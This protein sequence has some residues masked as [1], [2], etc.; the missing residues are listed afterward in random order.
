M[1]KR[2]RA[3][4]PPMPAELKQ[5]RNA[6]ACRVRPDLYQKVEAEAKRLQLPKSRFVESLLLEKFG[7]SLP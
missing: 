3:G 5:V 4:R 7:A 6:I 1:E 2:Q